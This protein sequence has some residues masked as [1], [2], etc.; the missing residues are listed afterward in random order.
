MAKKDLISAHDLSVQEI[1]K[2]FALTDELKVDDE[3][4][5]VALEGKTLALI[6]QKPS[7]R[8][9]VSFEVG[10]TQLGGHTIYLGPDDIKLGVREATKDVAGVL[11]RYVDGIV[12][13]TFAHNDILELAKNSTVPVINGLSDLLHPCQA[14]A[15]VYTIK[16]KLGRL[17]GVR[18]AFVGD[19]N[20]VLHSLLHCC[21]KVGIDLS[22]AT[23]KGYEPDKKIVKEAEDE[24][25]KSGGKLN[26]SNDPKEAVKGS[27]VVY[28]DVWISMGQEKEYKKR[29]K[30]FKGFQVN[31]KLVSLAKKGCLIMHC[32]PAHRGQEITDEVLD[33]PNSII[34]DQAENRMHV[35][36]AILLMLLGGIK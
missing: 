15:D 9:R 7:N 25:K 22:I 20:N 34:L 27:D 33:S 19:G 10:M 31:K 24:L 32:L 28:T 35:Q 8:T 1:N 26:F 17:E 16:E 2:L 18:V 30:A 4:F 29:V 3:K 6:F 36:K 13:R 12:A 5:T 23:P 21:S 14:M 11:S